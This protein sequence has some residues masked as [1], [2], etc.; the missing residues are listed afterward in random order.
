MHIAS[1]LPLVLIIGL[2]YFLMIRPQMR[3][4]K[5]HKQLLTNLKAG[6]EIVTTGGMI[7]KIA[8]VGDNFIEVSVADNLSIKVRKN[9]IASM[10]PK[11]SVKAD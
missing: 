8:K 11:G 7:G 9:A 3:R 5:E 2:F 1:F 6:D 10:L 4:N